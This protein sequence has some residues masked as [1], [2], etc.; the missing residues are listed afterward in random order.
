MENLIDLFA[1][2]LTRLERKKITRKEK[3]IWSPSRI[4]PFQL[5]EDSVIQAWKKKRDK[6]ERRAS[7][8]GGAKIGF[9]IRL[10]PVFKIIER[11]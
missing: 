9:E 11:N 2:N 4:S 5:S 7:N 10:V 3:I 1:R 6:K 8:G